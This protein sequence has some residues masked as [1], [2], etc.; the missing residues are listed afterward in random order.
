MRRPSIR[1]WP[2]HIFL[3]SVRA[4]VGKRSDAHK[5]TKF[6]RTLARVRTPRSRRKL[7]FIATLL[8]RLR[9]IRSVGK[10]R[11]FR[12]LHRRQ[13]NSATYQIRRFKQ[14]SF[15][16]ARGILTPRNSVDFRRAGCH[17]WLAHQCLRSLC[18]ASKIRRAKP[19]TIRY[20][21]APSDPASSSLQNSP[22]P[23]RTSHAH[24]QNQSQVTS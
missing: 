14:A 20:L 12:D 19:R 4:P 21:D 23:R 22:S 13:T 3:E 15:W 24:E 9:S 16:P 10:R 18:D 2:A 5:P 17:W 8:S 11:R 7:N 1:R 6:V